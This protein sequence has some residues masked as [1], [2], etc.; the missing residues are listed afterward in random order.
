[1][2]AILKLSPDVSKRSSTTAAV[3]FDLL[4]PIPFGFFVG[5]LIFDVVYANSAV[6][7]W[8]KS[9]AWLILIGLLFA[10]VPRLINLARVWF[11]GARPSSARDKGAFFLY[12]LGVAAA[13]FNAFV[14]GRDAYAIVPEGLWLS[15]LTVV[16]LVAS[17][18]LLTLQHSNTVHRGQA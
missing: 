1:M 15:I 11:P 4:N 6:V 9:A 5:A 18:I 8:F 14:H 13:I 16:L 12:L 2:M 3:L 17:N 10:V 7:M